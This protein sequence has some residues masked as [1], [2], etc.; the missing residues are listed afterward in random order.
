MVAG[1]GVLTKTNA[2]FNI[3]LLP[4]SLLLFN[5]GE[6]SVKNRLSKLIGLFVISVALTYGFYSILRL[7]PFFSYNSSKNAVFVYSFK[8]WLDHPLNFFTGNLRSFWDWVNRYLTWPL[9]VFAVGSFFVSKSFLREKLVLFFGS[10]FHLLG[11]DFSEEPYIL[12]L[13]SL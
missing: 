5:W 1:G 2:F 11:S 3:Y 10:L 6:R 4:F 13:F 9:L 8:E 7:S 12:V